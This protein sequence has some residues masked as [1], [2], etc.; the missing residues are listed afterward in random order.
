MSAD[1]Q[2]T[3]MEEISRENNTVLYYTKASY[4]REST[5]IRAILPPILKPRLIN[6][7]DGKSFHLRYVRPKSVKYW[8]RKLVLYFS[9]TKLNFA[10]ERLDLKHCM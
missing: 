3:R 5:N 6:T 1:L 2:I 7:I 4:S 10:K 8:R 9:I